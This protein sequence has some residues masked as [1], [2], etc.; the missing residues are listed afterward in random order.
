MALRPSFILAPSLFFSNF[1]MSATSISSSILSS[2]ISSSPR[3]QFF[4]PR[5]RP[6]QF[7]PPHPTFDRI[8][9][10]FADFRTSTHSSFLLSSIPCASLC[11]FST[12]YS[13]QR[14]Y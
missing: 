3:P 12:T 5:F 10:L 4:P 2:S 11:P 9:H 6:P 1:F 8:F 14:G 7:C 13:P